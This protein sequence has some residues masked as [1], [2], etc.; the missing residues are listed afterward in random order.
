MWRGPMRCGNTN[1]ALAEDLHLCAT[2]V[3]LLEQMI[4]SSG[5]PSTSSSDSES[6]SVRRLP[7]LQNVQI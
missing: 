4:R 1:G 7:H 6:G 2:Y 5:V 3:K